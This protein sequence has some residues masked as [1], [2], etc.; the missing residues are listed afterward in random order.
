MFGRKRFAKAQWVIKQRLRAEGM[1]IASQMLRRLADS[2]HDTPREDLYKGLMCA[3][4]FASVM[5]AALLS[6]DGAMGVIDLGDG[7]RMP[8][9]LTMRTDL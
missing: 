6:E 4:G 8:I 7:E 1:Q 3:S 9:D 2:V 5:S